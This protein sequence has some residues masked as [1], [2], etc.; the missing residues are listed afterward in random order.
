MFRRQ[1]LCLAVL[2]S[3]YSGRDFAPGQE[4]AILQEPA[5]G[6]IQTLSLSPDGR[7]LAA[8][9]VDEQLR[10]WDLQTG[11]RLLT[12]DAKTGS[13]KPIFTPDGQTILRQASNG[14]IR[15]WSVVTGKGG[16]AFT[17]E[18]MTAVSPDGKVVAAAGSSGQLRLLRGADG[19]EL[20]T[21]EQ[22]SRGISAVALS[23]DGKTVAVGTP[24]PSTITVWTGS[25]KQRHILL[26]KGSGTVVAL[27][28]SADGQRLMSDHGDSLRFWDLAKKTQTAEVKAQ[29]GFAFAPDNRTFAGTSLQGLTLWDAVTG[30]QVL[31]CAESRPAI[32]AVF[33][34]AGGRLLASRSSDGEVKLW[35]VA[36]DS[37]KRGKELATLQ[38]AV[39][40]I[41][42]LA[43]DSAS[44]FLAAGYED[45]A[46]K[47]WSLAGAGELTFS[48][49]H[50]A[51]VE[52]ILW[53]SSGKTVVTRCRSAVRMWD[54]MSGRQLFRL[55]GT[56]LQMVFSPDDSL[57]AASL[58]DGSVHLW[59]PARPNETVQ[60]PASAGP[61][62]SLTVAFVQ[63]SQTLVTRTN[64]SVRVW[65]LATR[66][67]R[68][69]LSQIGASFI[70]QG[71]KTL[72]AYPPFEQLRFWDLHAVDSKGPPIKE[73]AA[74]PLPETMFPVPRSS[75][76]GTLMVLVSKPAGKVTL[77]DMAAGKERA[78]I[79]TSLRTLEFSSDSQHFA[80]ADTTGAV[81]VF[82]TADGQVRQQ[83]PAPEKPVRRLLFAPD[84]KTLSAITDDG[85]ALLWDLRPR[86][87]RSRL[88]GKYRVSSDALVSY[89]ADSKN[90]IW[91]QLGGALHVVDVTTGQEKEPLGSPQPRATV[92]CATPD[93]AKVIAGYADGALT[94]WDANP[95]SASFGAELQHLDGNGR[96][97]LSL[98]L[99]PDSTR[100]A[101]GRADGQ[102]VLWDLAADHAP[103]YLAAHK[104]ADF[105]VAFST[106]GKKLTT[107]SDDATSVWD[108]D[109]AKE[110]ARNAFAAKKQV[111]VLQH[112]HL[113]V[114]SGDDG[115]VQ[116]RDLTSAQTVTFQGAAVLVS[117]LAFS[118]DGAMLASGYRD[119]TIKFWDVAAH[120]PL[121]S[122]KAHKSPVHS[123]VFADNGSILLSAASELQ[124]KL[125]DRATG[126]QRATIEVPTETIQVHLSPDGARLLTGGVKSGL[127]LWDTA[128][129]KLLHAYPVPPGTSATVAFS[130]DGKILALAGRSAT[131]PIR[132]IQ[133][134]SG[135][136]HKTLEGH[137]GG[138]LTMLF[139]PD[140]RTLVT[141]GADKVVKNWNVAS[142]A[143]EQRIAQ[144][145]AV[146]A[147]IFQREGTTLAIGGKD[148]S[149]E[150]WD[151]AVPKRLDTLQRPGSPVS[152]L[153]FDAA[154]RTL[155]TLDAAGHTATLWD[156]ATNEA[157]HR[158]SECHTAA[159]SPDGKSLTIWHLEGD[160]KLYDAL[161]A[162]EQA[163]L[164][165]YQTRSTFAALV[166][167]PT[168]EHL[169]IQAQAAVPVSG[170]YLHVVKLDGSKKALTIKDSVRPPQFSRDG[171]LLMSVHSDVVKVWDVNLA[172]HLSSTGPGLR[173]AALSADGKWIAAASAKEKTLRLYDARTGN[174]HATLHE[175]TYRFM[176]LAFDSD[177]KLLAGLTEGRDRMIILWDLATGKERAR[178]ADSRR[179]SFSSL[180]FSP[181]GST[182]ANAAADG[183][184][185]L[186]DTK[187]G[188]ECVTLRPREPYRIFARMVLE[189]SPDGSTLAAGESNGSLRLWH[190]RIARE[191]GSLHGHGGAVQAVAVTRDGKLFATASAD[192]TVKLW[193]GSNGKLTATLTGHAGLVLAAVFS[194][195]GRVLAT[196]SADRTVKLWDTATFRELATLTG[197]TDVVWSVAFNTDGKLLASGS[198]DRT[199]KLWALSAKPGDAAYGQ[200][201]RTLEGH[202]GEVFAVAFAPHRPLLVSGDGDLFQ[203]SRPGVLRFWDATT[204]KELAAVRGHSGAIRTLAFAPDG[205]TLASGGWDRTLKLWSVDKIHPAMTARASLHGHHQ[206]IQHLAFAPD[207]QML[208]T[209]AGNPLSP[210][211]AGELFLWDVRTGRLRPPLAG[212]RSGL[213]AVAFAHDGASILASS[214][215]ETIR[216][217]SLK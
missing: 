160:V 31:T 204:G 130:P 41:T 53:A 75:P 26:E 169:A 40:E 72:V 146:T 143:Q 205:Q 6:G 43:P 214:F 137:S 55:P 127:R 175:G 19:K 33:F 107:L 192:K 16:D 98:A 110:T 101:A 51:R 182:L 68:Q 38:T 99:A 171:G 112:Q 167:S 196:S 118:P 49:K 95:K 105:Q 46:V 52:Q 165:N 198:A 217:W 59:S 163:S 149:L 185:K 216:W 142:G 28:F 113:L 23:P 94:L 186:W 54:P 120:Q 184:V 63:G 66:T 173:S 93:G 126:A 71:G 203:T 172:T 117:Q 116:L 207:G 48:G 139:S 193:N 42:A 133:A 67:Q 27:R 213:T 141:G 135:A 69:E 89:T 131:A 189:F 24:D 200:L 128:T 62:K 36:A 61:V 179:V 148:G 152:N 168:G 181:D 194:P 102:A 134:H 83:F 197:H 177:S 156:L 108:V 84:G 64:Q 5:T 212:H 124:N 3:C 187:T 73:R 109:A 80:V 18:P 129:G 10:L 145:A 39:R 20:A 119:G 77:I 159:L 92:L 56:A 85:S 37:A 178:L 191:I 79:K 50:T 183:S 176:E 58:N 140:S 201:L 202:E 21:L 60:L 45:G 32:E 206:P 210:R 154:G 111:A 164:G 162:K 190:A 166:F 9:G 97:I 155:L 161:T 138:T 7:I 25:P 125:W 17:S 90:L 82:A 157:R 96:A 14:E 151:L 115:R 15:S 65:D 86:L 136:E 153:H 88:L 1:L 132:L 199:I 174:E 78:T 195:D 215:D 170:G 12:L 44:K 22:P 106:D 74:L 29:R 34:V 188:T 30:R 123:L 87:F 104:N 81:T 121:T 11:R 211:E 91:S 114:A 8:S 158:F 209:A 13:G 180:R 57:L 4:K 2:L 70:A 103:V 150:L 144:S 122:F 100:L 147:M 208:A 35:D 76:D 47:K